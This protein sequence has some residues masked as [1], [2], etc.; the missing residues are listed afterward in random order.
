VHNSIYYC[1]ANMPGAVPATSTVALTNAT[2]RHVNSLANKGWKAALAAEA[3]LGK[4]LNTTKGLLTNEPVG[5]AHGLDATSV[6]G[7]LH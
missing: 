5:V 7:Q 6:E 1:V 4:G 3:G 2:M